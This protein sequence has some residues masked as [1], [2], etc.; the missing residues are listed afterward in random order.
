M[1]PPTAITRNNKVF[2]YPDFTK[3]LHFEGELVLRICKNGKKIDEQFA[4]KYVDGITVGIDLTARDL[5]DKLKEKG[6]PW[7][8][9]KAFDGSAVVGNF[10]ELK[11]L[12]DPIK[13]SLKK[14]GAIAQ[15]GNSADMLFSCQKII[16]Y[17]SNFFTLLKGD[18]IFTGTPTGVGPVQIDD[19]FEGFLE[20]QNVLK[21]KIK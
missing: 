7:E 14:N 15:N 16:S 9:A 8:I 5:Q 1:K 11:N 18:L 10:V 12:E 4:A 13:F 20:E 2:F 21:V 17:I 6:L 19:V 3:N